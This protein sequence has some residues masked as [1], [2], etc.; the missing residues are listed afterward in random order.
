MASQ[1]CVVLCYVLYSEVVCA[2]SRAVD[3]C[4]ESVFV[5]RSGVDRLRD[6]FF[7][8]KVVAFIEL[9]CGVADIGLAVVLDFH[10]HLAVFAVFRGYRAEHACEFQTL[11]NKR[12]GLVAKHTVVECAGVVLLWLA[13]FGE[14]TQDAAHFHVG[15]VHQ[16]ECRFV[17]LARVTGIDAKESVL[18]AHI[19]FQLHCEAVDWNYLFADVC[20]TGCTVRFLRHYVDFL[21]VF[22]FAWAAVVVGVELHTHAHLLFRDI[23]LEVEASET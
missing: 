16:I 3:A 14:E 21:L 19:L 22:Q 12:F 20:R 18:D 1:K 8:Q 9:E 17:L 10:L 13:V 5:C 15:V 2:F 7:C 6:A 4:L 23:V 11:V